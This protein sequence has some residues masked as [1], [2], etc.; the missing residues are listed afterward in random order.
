MEEGGGRP[1]T[2][3]VL[4]AGIAG[5]C[6]AMQL[7][8]YRVGGVPAFRVFQFEKRSEVSLSLLRQTLSFLHFFPASI[9]WRPTLV[10]VRHNSPTN[11]SDLLRRCSLVQTEL[12]RLNS[13]LLGNPGD[14]YAAFT[15][16]EIDSLRKQG[17]IPAPQTLRDWVQNFASSPCDL[18]QLQFPIIVA[19]EP[20]IS[21]INA[22]A[23]V[24]LAYEHLSAYWSLRL[25]TTVTTVKQTG[26]KWQ[27][28][29]QSV[30]GETSVTEVDFL[31]NATGSQSGRFDLSANVPFPRLFELKL[32]Y[33]VRERGVLSAPSPE[34]V[35]IGERARDKT[36][37]DRP[38]C[39]V[40]LTPYGNGLWQIHAMAGDA[41]LCTE[42]VVGCQENSLLPAMSCVGAMAE[43]RNWSIPVLEQRYSAAIAHAAVLYP[44]LSSAVGLHIP[45]FGGYQLIPGH[46]AEQRVAAVHTLEKYAGIPLVKA[47]AGPSDAGGI[48]EYIVSVC[49]PGGRTAV[50]TREVHRA[51]KTEVVLRGKVIARRRSLP[52][53]LVETDFQPW[54]RL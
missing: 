42:G 44:P 12:N 15:R 33:L 14:Y 43:S 19:R 16:E 53:E 2:V 41:T 10:A 45:P 8:R 4:G 13:T 30:S 47:V 50:E 9:I 54:S 6:C 31:V 51:G 21:S 32:T 7:L 28:A 17:P 34:L 18:S 25:D 36:V 23:T 26:E 1:V 35:F 29:W 3:G 37:A 20:G 40:Q 22:A 46:C 48:A 24:E 49:V 11:P 52:V 38:N 27:V 39:F 5:C